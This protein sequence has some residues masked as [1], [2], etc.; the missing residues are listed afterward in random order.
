MLWRDLSK[1]GKWRKCGSEMGHSPAVLD[2]ERTEQPAL[3][4][5]GCP[6]WGSGHRTLTPLPS[7][8]SC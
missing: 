6:P 8:S 7:K 5:H 3:T 1:E 2:R 4:S